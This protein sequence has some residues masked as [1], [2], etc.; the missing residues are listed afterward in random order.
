[1]S[2]L[3][4]SSGGKQPQDFFSPATRSKLD[5]PWDQGVQ[6]FIQLDLENIQGCITSHLSGRWEVMVTCST[7]SLFLTMDFFFLS[8][9]VLS[10]SCSSQIPLLLFLSPVLLWR[11][12]LHFVS[13]ILLDPDRLLL[14]SS[15]PFLQAEDTQLPQPLLTGQMFQAPTTSLVLPWSHSSTLIS[16]LYRGGAKVDALF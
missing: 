9:Y 16:F 10:W 5:Q 15:S 13:N 12:W 4:L 14:R 7:T 2:R 1:M 6:S 8:H 11:G 3:C